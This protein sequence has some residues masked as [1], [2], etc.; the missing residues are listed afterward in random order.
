[1]EKKDVVKA[2][3]TGL[4]N[5]NYKAI[6][7]LFSA[8]AV[9]YSPLYGKA[10]ATHFYQDLFLDTQNSI[11]TLKNI[12]L[13]IDNPNCVAAQFVYAWTMKDG[14]L[15]QF[16]CVDIFEFNDKKINSLTIIYDTYQTRQN[17]EKLLK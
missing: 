10:K 8:E 4:E 3:L 16:E 15:N 6:I 1:M 11:I 2:Y 9:V 13:S 14:S 5:K 12:F 7:E 17:F